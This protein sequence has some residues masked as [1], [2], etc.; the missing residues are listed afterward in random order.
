MITILNHDKENIFIKIIST[1][2]SKQIAAVEGADVTNLNDVI[3]YIRNNNIKNVYL[4]V[5]YYD[6]ERKLLENIAITKAHA[7]GNVLKL[8]SDGNNNTEEN[9]SKD[10]S[11]VKQ[12]K[13]N[14]KCPK[15]GSDEGLVDKDGNTHPCLSCI[16]IDI[17][18]KLMDK[19]GK[20]FALVVNKN[21]LVIDE[22]IK[23]FTPKREDTE[24]N[25]NN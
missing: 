20:E 10:S 5:S 12:K 2:Q 19:I 1:E 14:F 21:N 13:N 16:Q 3:K 6:D 15:C 4:S 25:S 22:L 11:I 23:I 7:L 8:N 18:Q 9:V 24:E 17:G